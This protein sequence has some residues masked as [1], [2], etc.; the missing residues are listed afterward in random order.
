MAYIYKKKKGESVYYYLRVSVRKGDLVRSRDV[1]YLGKDLNEKF[2]SDVEKKYGKE[3]KETLKVLEKELESKYFDRKARDLKVRSSDY[4]TK[5]ELELIEKIRL[6]YNHKL[7]NMNYNDLEDM[8][9]EFVTAFAYNSS[10]IEG[11]T[12]PL[13]D[14]DLLLNERISPKNKNMEEVYMIE[15]TELAFRY[16]RENNPEIN[17]DLVIKLHDI[18]V[19]R[20][21]VRLGYRKIPIRVVKSRFEASKPEHIKYDMK[22][23]FD[24]YE[25]NKNKLH[26]LALAV[27]F[28]HKFEVIHPFADG[29][30]RTGR[31]IMN[32]MLEKFGYAP[33][34]IE[35]KRRGKYLEALNSCDK[36]ARL[37]SS[38]PELY[39]KLFEFM[40]REYEI[41]Y[42]LFF[43]KY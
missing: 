7:K 33:F 14:V 34:V 24:W 36:K 10:A 35:V 12:L 25:K 29:N 28:H 32:Y 8:K 22:I 40:A 27:L 41:S 38:E 11:N 6:E 39:A 15:N 42:N 20:I 9:V 17:E 5:R 37:D 2:L 16:L 31:M 43:S 1:L 26:P 23:L 3:I 21:D 4:F 30:G 18:L 13:R 19:D